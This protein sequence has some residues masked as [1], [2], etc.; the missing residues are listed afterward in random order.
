MILTYMETFM[1]HTREV[2]FEV[3]YQKGGKEFIPND[4]AYPTRVPYQLEIGSN[5]W[6]LLPDLIYNYVSIKLRR[7]NI[8][9]TELLILW[10]VES[11]H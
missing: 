7:R 10:T 2:V 4:P 3:C 5:L 9:P 6:D 11:L 1:P 8:D